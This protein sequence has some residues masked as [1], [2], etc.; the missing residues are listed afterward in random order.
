MQRD[1]SGCDAFWSQWALPPAS[2]G[3]AQTLCGLLLH[4]RLAGVCIQSASDYSVNVYQALLFR[5]GSRILNDGSWSHHVE[6][7]SVSC[8]CPH[9]LLPAARQLITKLCIELV[10]QSNW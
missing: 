3:T 8:K 10:L 5:N 4:R 1:C 7:Q 9:N 6:N 2:E